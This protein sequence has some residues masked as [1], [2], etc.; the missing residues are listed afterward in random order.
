MKIQ[1]PNSESYIQM[2]CFEGSIPCEL[3][4]D[5]ILPD[6]YPDV[7][8]ILRTTA[9]PVII[10]RYISGDK[11]EFS[12]AVDYSVI[13]S[14]ED[15][16]KDTIHCVHFAGDFNGVA[17]DGSSLDTADISIT[18]RISACTARLSN[19]RKISIRTSVSCDVKIRTLMSCQPK[20]GGMTTSD[21]EYKLQKLTDPLKFCMQRTFLADPLR[22]SADIGIDASMPPVDSVISCKSD[23]AINEAR[24]QFTGEGASVVLKGAAIVNFICKS[25][26][27]ADDYRSFEE[28]LPFTH[29]VSADDIS[30]YFDGCSTDE[31]SARATAV[32]IELNA[33]VSED[34]Y[35]ERRIIEL[36]L[37]ADV[38]VHVYGCAEAA[39]VLDVYS[40]ERETVCGYSDMTV[41]APKKLIS[42]NFSVGEN[43]PLTDLKLPEGASVINTSAEMANAK[44]DVENG[45]ALLT[46]NAVISCI[47]KDAEGNCGSAEA[48]VP[49]KYEFPSGD[50][51]A[52]TEYECYLSASDMRM[53]TD[54]ERAWF[55]FEVSV[56]AELAGRL[57]RRVVSTV[58]FGDKLAKKQTA[59]MT[60]CYK[61]KN[62]TMWDIAK[63]YGTTVE[64]LE[65]ANRANARVLIIP[66]APLGI[67]I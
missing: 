30:S 56:N 6:T 21:G 9:S 26:A 20:C 17:S 43:I 25:T 3:S 55:D 54:G 1:A 41:T 47:Y 58:T 53:R 23:I 29:T 4:A 18:P 66:R 45:R 5:Y 48:V 7:K 2:P 33:R 60:L 67:V 34:N 11:A 28:K 36:D 40:T 44:A 31:L 24:P 65:A 59:A 10:N 62:D 12:G 37:S 38:T 19:P 61:S 39:P 52:P 42:T 27:S 46:A 32:P 50:M 8:R 51:S 57:R 64:A 63:R 13:F 22:L 16:G 15:N 35:G 49:V 14:S